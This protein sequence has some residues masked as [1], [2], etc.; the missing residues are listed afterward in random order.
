M[1]KKL[2]YLS[3]TFT[4]CLFYAVLLVNVEAQTPQPQDIGAF[5]KLKEKHYPFDSI[6]VTARVI[7]DLTTI[8]DTPGFLKV[9]SKEDP[10]HIVYTLRASFGENRNSALH[11]DFWTLANFE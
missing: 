10:N 3:I 4:L 1:R 7:G 6:H 2:F 8:F 5:S 11:I 9:L